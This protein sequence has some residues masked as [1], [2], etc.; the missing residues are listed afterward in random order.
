MS[1]TTL[2]ANGTTLFANETK[3]T[4]NKGVSKPH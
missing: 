1:E 4:A 3:L 2:T